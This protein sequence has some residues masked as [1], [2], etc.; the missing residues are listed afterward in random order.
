MHVGPASPRN[1]VRIGNEKEVGL[2]T[3]RANRTLEMQNG[4]TVGTSRRLRTDDGLTGNGSTTR[5]TGNPPASW[6]KW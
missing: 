5:K 6:R 1:G 4:E 2:S 3:D